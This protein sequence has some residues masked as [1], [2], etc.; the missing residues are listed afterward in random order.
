MTVKMTFR[1]QLT[2]AAVALQLGHAAVIAGAAILA[3]KAGAA[4]GIVNSLGGGIEAAW[5]EVQGGA[6]C[7]P[8][9][10]P[11]LLKL[12]QRWA[13]RRDSQA[14]SLK[15]HFHALTR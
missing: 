2:P 1:G 15:E 14:H 11:L 6:T 5:D 12:Q 4:G 10:Q 7:L 9:S 13:L 8:P 3:P